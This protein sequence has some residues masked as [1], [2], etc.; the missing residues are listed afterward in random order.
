VALVLMTVHDRKAKTLRSLERVALQR[1]DAGVE[2]GVVLVDDGCTDGTAE[3]VRERFPDVRVVTGP[4][5]LFWN[6][7]MRRAFE[8]AMVEN[9]DFYLLLN[10]DTDLLPG[11]LRTLLETH[12]ER[13]QAEGRPCLVVGSTVDPATGKHSYGGWRRGGRW[14]PMRLARIPPGPATRPCDTMNG[15]CVLVPRDVVRRVG[16]LDAAFTHRMG[17]LDYGFRAARDG[18][19]IWLAPGFLAECEENSGAGLF[20][21]PTLSTREQWRRLLGPRG[22]PPPE[23]L[24]FTSRHAGPL[25]PVIFGWPYLK[26]WLNALSRRP[27]AGAGRS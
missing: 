8:V 27:V 6:G 22:L 16:I 20:V 1:V 24:T 7:G 25:W 23:W 13:T 14:N 4:G 15:N 3:A 11:A 21:D 5:N 2:L 18:C 19:G 12:A 17:D 10:D 9:P 26:L